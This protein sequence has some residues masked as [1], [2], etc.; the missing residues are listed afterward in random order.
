MWLGLEIAMVPMLGGGIFSTEMD[1]MKAVVAALI[2]HLI[3]GSVFGAIAGGAP[4]AV[5]KRIKEAA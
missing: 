1:G 3:Y 5:V 4:P 2:G